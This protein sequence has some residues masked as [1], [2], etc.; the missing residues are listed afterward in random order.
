MVKN[1]DTD[2]LE[3]LDKLSYDDFLS[4]SEIAKRLD[5]YWTVIIK[6][7]FYLEYKGYIKFIETRTLG[8]IG[9]LW[10]RLKDGEPI[11]RSRSKSIEGY[12]EFI[13]EDF[14]ESTTKLLQK[15]GSGFNKNPSIVIAKLLYLRAKGEIVL[16]KSGQSKQSYYWRRLKPKEKE[17]LLKNGKPEYFERRYQ[18]DC[19]QQ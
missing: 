4:T 7:L 3:I 19:F 1:K 2:S 10:K 6:K 13:S 11:N 8:G 9:Y 18:R 14:F 16:F 5:S 15:I 12:L 17:E